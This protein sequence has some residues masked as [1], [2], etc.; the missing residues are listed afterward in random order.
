MTALG[1][2]GV[3]V[4]EH[5]L[6]ELGQVGAQVEQSAR[7]DVVG[8]D[9]VAERPGA[10]AQDVGAA[11]L[12]VHRRQA[13]LSVM[14]TLVMARPGSRALPGVALGDRVDDVHALD[15]APEHGVLAVEVRRG[16]V[17]D[18]EL[19]AVRAGAGVGHGEHARAVVAQARVELVG[20]P[21]AGAAAAGA[22]G[23]AGLRHE[24]AG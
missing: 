2:L 12:A 17:G 13:S 8:R 3:G 16:L 22:R 10:A 15:D 9:V 5:V 14:V 20:E 4:F 7:R 6:G 19:R 24:V 18:E 23:V 11:G 21:V 1:E